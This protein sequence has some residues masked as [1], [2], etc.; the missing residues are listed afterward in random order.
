MMKK[1]LKYTALASAAMMAMATPA[2][3]ASLLLGFEGTSQLGNC[4]LG[5]CFRPP[6]TMG[7]VG[8]NHYLESSNGSFQAF[9][10]TGSLLQTWA[11]PNFWSN[12]GLANAGGGDNRVMFD[13]FSQ[14]W[15]A[16]GFGATN[17]IINVAVSA[18]DN[19]LGAWNGTAITVLP[20]GTADYPTLAIDKDAVYIGTNNFTPGFTGTS[21]L[22]LPRTSAFTAGGPTT[23]GLTTFTTSNAG[24]DNGFA[25]QGVNSNDSDG[26]GRVVA[27]SRVADYNVAYDIT[28]P[29]GPGTAQTASGEIIGSDYITGPRGRQPDGTRT[30][31]TLSPRITGSA[32]ESD[33][34]I[35][36]ATTVLSSTGTGA[37]VRIVVI[38]AVTKALLSKTEISD[39]NFDFYQGSLAINASGKLVVGYNRSGYQTTDLNGDGK[40]DGNISV[41]ARVFNANADGTITQTDDILIRVSDTST[42]HCTVVAPATTCRE[43]WGDYAAVSLDPTNND[44]FWV[45]GEYAQPEGIIPGF[46]TTPRSVWGTYIGVIGTGKT[47]GAVPEPGTWMMMLAGFGFVGGAMRRRTRVRVSYSL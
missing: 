1:H 16:I 6:D 10:K 32:W 12:A 27:D 13:T 9:S 31:D 47:P 44:N 37:A 11:M 40:A 20:S 43:R 25:I 3:A 35:Y 19:A 42:Y 33:G 45:I 17:N 24:P 2:S 7:A 46:T 22:V 23:T 5:Q 18:T 28:N 39:P 36:Y 29:G 21:L 38:D 14:R 41:M 30:V 26:V 4:A 8:T 34:K 15:M